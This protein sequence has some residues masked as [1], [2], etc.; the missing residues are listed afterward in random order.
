ME[1]IVIA[2]YKPKPGKENALDSLMKTHVAVLQREGL[3]TERQSVM[4]KAADGT[5]IDGN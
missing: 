4:M 2:C 3:A 5:V 1:R